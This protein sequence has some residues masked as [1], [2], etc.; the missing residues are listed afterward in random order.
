MHQIVSLVVGLQANCST[1]EVQRQKTPIA[2]SAV[3]AW[4]KTYPGRTKI[5]S[6]MFRDELN[7]ASQVRQCLTRQRLVHEAASDLELDLLANRQPV[8]LT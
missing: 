6:I 7:V 3:C 5:L 4:Y 2:E 8:Q 1:H